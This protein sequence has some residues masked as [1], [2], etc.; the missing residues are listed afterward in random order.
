MREF[1]QVL[2]LGALFG[3]ATGNLV[4]KAQRLDAYSLN[5][6]LRLAEQQLIDQAHEAGLKV[7]VYTVN[8]E[9]DIQQMLRLNVD[10][11]FTNYPDRVFALIGE[12]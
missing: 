5:L 2:K 8:V 3:K 7:F 1:D 12:D 6:G 4:E 9:E 10:G 11:V